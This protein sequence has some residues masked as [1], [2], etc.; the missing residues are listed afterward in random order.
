MNISEMGVLKMLEAIEAW[1]GDPNVHEL[2]CHGGGGNCCGFKGQGI[3]LIPKIKRT[4]QHVN[5]SGQE[6]SK[7]VL[8]CPECK[9]I[10]EKVPDCVYQW[11][12]DTHMSH[13]IPL[14]QVVEVDITDGCGMDAIFYGKDYVFDREIGGKVYGK[15]DEGV[16]G[17]K[18]IA[19]Y[20]V[21]KLR[22]LV[23]GYTR[24]C[25]G[26]P[27]YCLSNI[28]VKYNCGS[29]PDPLRSAM[30]ESI[31]Y[32]QHAEYLKTGWSED[33]LKVCEGELVPLQYNSIFEYEKMLSR[34]LMEL[35]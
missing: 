9:R 28:R 7:V 35:L 10:Q 33:S 24:D 13:A 21:G 17:D 27:L 23:V 14:G 22:A 30:A 5:L 12:I 34:E 3:K 6:G 8:E 15:P 16:E 18:E 26:T 4:A 32:K 1:Q 2:T 29:L 25:D 11:Y 31:K 20:F 19:L